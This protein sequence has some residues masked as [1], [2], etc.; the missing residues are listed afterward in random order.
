ML[1][2]INYLWWILGC[3]LLIIPIYIL[4]FICVYNVRFKRQSPLDI[5]TFCGYDEPYHPSVF[6]FPEKFGHYKYWMVESPYPIG[7][8]S[9]RDRWEC[10]S[11]HASVNGYDWHSVSEDSFPLDDLTKEEIERHSYHSD[12]HLLYAK[13]RLEC[14][15]R[16]CDVKDG[17]ISRTIFYRRTSDDGIT[18][19][20]REEMISWSQK[21]HDKLESNHLLYEPIDVLEDNDQLILSPAIIYREDKY[22]MWTCLSDQSK[23]R[24]YVSYSSSKNGKNWEPRIICQLE[25]YDQVIPWHLDVYYHEGIYYLLIYDYHGK[26]ITLWE[27]TNQTCFNFKSI[28]LRGDSR[29][30]SFYHNLYRA[31]IVNDGSWKIYFSASCSNFVSI[32]LLEGDSLDNL[33]MYNGPK[34]ECHFSYCLDDFIFHI[35]NVVRANPLTRPLIP[36][37]KN[38]RAKI[39]NR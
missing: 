31:S 14:W 38:I 19:S 10:P 29:I 34:R 37:A 17:D 11:I 33:T 25:G 20:S 15:Y 27:S 30:G 35:K 1:A 13:G 2:L 36:F 9:S 5:K 23:K 4:I 28:I 21:N 39:L 12:P 32:G 24:F 26:E 3:V 8:K 18:W 6:Y 22:H 16:F 7:A